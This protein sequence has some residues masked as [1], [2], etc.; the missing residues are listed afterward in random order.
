[1]YK[2]P[3]ADIE[4]NAP[5]WFWTRHLDRTKSR[6]AAN[7]VAISARIKAGDLIDKARAAIEAIAIIL[8]PMHHLDIPNIDMTISR[9]SP[10]LDHA[11]TELRQQ[12]AV[13]ARSLCQ[14]R[15]ADP[16][17]DCQADPAECTTETRSG[18]T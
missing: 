15:L 1:L 9:T 11:D 14:R 7:N 17:A 6:N 3:P 8:T 13:F 12:L 10:G 16:A 2:N 5:R 18:R 4:H